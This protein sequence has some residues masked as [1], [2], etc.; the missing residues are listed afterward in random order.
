MATTTT[1]DAAQGFEDWSGDVSSKL[2][3]GEVQRGNGRRGGV[4]LEKL[5]SLWIRF[6][7]IN[8]VCVYVCVCVRERERNVQ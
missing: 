4:G 1:V 8:C 6:C 7:V 3:I 2:K 5:E